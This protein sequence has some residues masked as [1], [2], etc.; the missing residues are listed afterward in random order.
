MEITYELAR[1]IVIYGSWILSLWLMLFFNGMV[2]NIKG[3]K[4]FTKKYDKL[5]KYDRISYHIYL[6][7]RV[8]FI[9]ILVFGLIY[10]YEEGL[11]NFNNEDLNNWKKL[12]TLR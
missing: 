12:L 4:L 6:V 3:V 10:C 5:D 8:A 9:V 1:K 2:L 7:S 11:F